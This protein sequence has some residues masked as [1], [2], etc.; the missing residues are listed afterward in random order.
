MFLALSLGCPAPGPTTP[1][2]AKRVGEA[3]AELKRRETDGLKENA[4]RAYVM[5]QIGNWIKDNAF[6]I[7]I[8]AIGGAISVLA[9]LIVLLVRF[10]AARHYRL[11]P[12]AL[13]GSP[14]EPA[15]PPPDPRELAALEAS[16]DYSRAIV[17]LHRLSVAHLVARGLLPAKNFTNEAIAARI[18]DGA[19]RGVFRVIAGES[20]RILFDRAVATSGDLARC[21]DEYRRAFREG[22]A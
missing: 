7:K 10:L 17:L 14:E 18:D 4:R 21:R 6:Y 5:S 8:A 19:L 3:L 13:P 22:R 16:G 15:A 2:D 1:P 11:A 12:A 9:F 20:E